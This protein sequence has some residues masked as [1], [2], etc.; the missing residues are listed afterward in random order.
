[1]GRDQMHLKQ[2]GLLPSHLPGS[3]P[4]DFSPPTVWTLRSAGAAGGKIMQRCMHGCSKVHA[5]PFSTQSLGLE[6]RL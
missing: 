5:N 4:T 1:M 2:F 3:F 6:P